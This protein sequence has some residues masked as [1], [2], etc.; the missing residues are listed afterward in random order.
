MYN[1]TMFFFSLC[2]IMHGQKILATFFTYCKNYLAKK[3]FNLAKFFLFYKI[4][5]NIFILS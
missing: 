2:S 3:K 5:T 4:K 1:E